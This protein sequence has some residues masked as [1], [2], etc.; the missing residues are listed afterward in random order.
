M[1][2][3]PR[4]GIGGL[5]RNVDDLLV[6]MATQDT[7]YL[8]DQPSLLKSKWP[9]Q[10]V[11]QIWRYTDGIDLY[12][13]I[14]YGQWLRYFFA[15]IR[16]IPTICH[17]AGT[18]VW[19]INHSWIHRLWFQWIIRHCITHHLAVAEHLKDELR[20]SDVHAVVVPLL[21]DLSKSNIVD[22]PKQFTILAYLPTNRSKFFHAEFVYELA[23]H[24]PE[25]EF[26]IVGRDC[27]EKGS[28]LPNA[29]EIGHIATLDEIYPQISVLVRLPIHDGLSRMVLEALSWGRYVVYAHPFPHTFQANSLDEV[30]RQLD[31]L[32]TVQKA[33]LAGAT[34]VRQ[35]FTES[36]TVALLT[37][38]F[39]EVL[40]GR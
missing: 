11:W 25:W 3:K 20:S 21:S 2:T 35:H 24:H 6:Q 10:I 23:E 38:T 4:I 16:G 7:F 5:R 8:I 9:W 26:I 29:H 32:S 36:Q 39:H 31:D 33:N 15:H 28:S 19:R 30:D 27:T 34:Y 37:K 14:G 17:W 1:N 12:Y 40:S 13:G 22:L 18:D